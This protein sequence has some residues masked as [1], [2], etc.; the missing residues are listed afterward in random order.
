VE[1]SKCKFTHSIGEKIMIRKNIIISISCVLLFVPLAFGVTDDQVLLRLDWKDKEALKYKCNLQTEIS[2]GGENLRMGMI[3]EITLRVAEMNEQI[4]FEN[5]EL[6]QSGDND[7][8]FFS[9]DEHLT[10]ID[11]L[12]GDVNIVTEFSGQKL[13]IKIQKDNVE[14]Y[15]N[16]DKLPAE[17]L[18]DVRNG[19]KELQDILNNPIRVTVTDFGRVVKVS[20]LD[21]FDGASQKDLAKMFFD[22]LSLPDKP[23][24]VGG[25]CTQKRDLKFLLPFGE[26]ESSAGKSLDIIHTLT[27]VRTNENGIRIAELTAPLKERFENVTIDENGTKGTAQYDILYTTLFDIKSGIIQC[28]MVKGVVKLYPQASDLPSVITVNIDASFKLI[29]SEQGQTVAQSF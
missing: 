20:G 29:E 19:A 3:N 11:L 15:L 27:K 23:M 8:G 12:Y 16:G 10:N 9:N 2:G 26:D 21:K 25:Q 1:Q 14:A 4:D 17:Q 13:S 7:R 24:K 6:D 5:K 18:S 22:G 28:E